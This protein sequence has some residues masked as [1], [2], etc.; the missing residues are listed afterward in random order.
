MDVG[1]EF[2]FSDLGVELEDFEVRK[3]KKMDRHVGITFGGSIINTPLV[4]KG[5]VYVGS[6]DQYVYAVDAKTSKEIWRFKTNGIIFQ[7]SIIL[8]DDILYLGSY[9]GCLYAIDVYG[10]EVWRFKTGGEVV[11]PACADKGMVYFGSRDGYV[12]CLRAGNGKVFWRF[13]TGDEIDSAPL[14]HGN[15]LFIGSFDGYLYCMNK[16]TGEEIWRF[17]TGGEIYNINP[18]ATH[19]NMLFFSSFDNNCYCVDM[20]SGKEIWRFQTG[21]FGNAASPV[22]HNNIL[23][24]PSRDG[25]LYALTPNGKEIWRFVTRENIGPPLVRNDR[26]YVGSCDN[27]LYAVDK[28]GKEVWRFQT[29]NYVFPSPSIWEDRVYVGAWDCHLYCLDRE[30]GKKIWAFPTSM[31]VDSKIPPFQEMWEVVIKKTGTED[32]GEDEQEKY[33]INVSVGLRDEYEKD[34]EYQVK[35][36]YQQKMKY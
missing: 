31:Q 29:T 28:K 20:E 6:C 2:S 35:V 18:F 33:E 11:C 26:I 8:H 32:K 15:K 27:N 9:D 5:I 24:V 34:S 21:N 16:K 25:I 17:K 30:T 22:L 1:N 4:Y 3:L 12:Y 7:S 19:K 10:K 23:Y 14:I 36:E 13:R